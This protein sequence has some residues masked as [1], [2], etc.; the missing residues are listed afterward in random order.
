MISTRTARL[1]LAFPLALALA[2]CGEDAET[3]G[4]IS[5]EPV[6]EVPAPEGTSWTQTTSVSDAG[7]YVMGNP[8]APIKLVEYASYTCGACAQF[9]ETGAEPLKNEYVES[10]R[11]SWELRNLIRD[12]ID[13]TVATLARCGSAESFHPLG[14]QVWLNF[15]E[16]MGAAQENGQALEAAM[17]RPENER[18]TGVAEAAGLLDFFAARGLSR[19]QARQC[20]ADTQNVQ[21]IAEQ[22][23]QLANENNVTGT[24]TFFLNG[25]QL[26]E[27]SW[28]QL[29]GALQ[30]AGAR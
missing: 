29:E 25:R 6:A 12:P 24:P 28:D 20:L 9:I 13:L 27:R 5:G 18:L 26:E 21:A 4:D 17:S 14:E 8:D 15:Q 16:V 10:G 3:G 11:V 23:T 30:R 7:G 19:D 22:S 1:A 2:A